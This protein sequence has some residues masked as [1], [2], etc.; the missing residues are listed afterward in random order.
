MGGSV[1]LGDNTSGAGLV[2]VRG[3][4]V[5]GF[6]FGLGLGF[7]L[8]SSERLSSCVTPSSEMLSTCSLGALAG[9]LLGELRFTGSPARL[10]SNIEISDPVGAIGPESTISPL[11]GEPS[12]L[13]LLRGVRALGL[14]LALRLAASVAAMKLALLGSVPPLAALG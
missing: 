11:L 8:V 12:I 5:N 14:G 6:G 4:G 10:C 3:S 1:G 9:A 7:D 2:G 13:V